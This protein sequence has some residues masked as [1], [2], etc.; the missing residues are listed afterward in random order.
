MIHDI[1]PY[2]VLKISEL[3]KLIVSQLVLIS[4][5]SSDR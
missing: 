3:T 1:M 2:H 4:Q 5:K